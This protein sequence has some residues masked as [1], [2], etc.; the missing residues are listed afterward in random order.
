MPS[1]C[2]SGG[3]TWAPSGETIAVMQPPR[4][5]LR[6]FSSGEI[7]AICSSVSQPVALTTK[8]PL[9]KRVVADRHLDLLGENRSNHRAG[10]LGDV[11]FFVLRHQGVAGERIVVLP[12]GQRADAADGGIDNGEARAIAL[13]PDHPFMECRRDLAALER[14]PAVGVENKLRVVERTVIALVDAEHD[15]DVYGASP[16][17]ATASVTGPGTITAFS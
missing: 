1:P 9:S 2:V 12:A 13:P 17:A 10:K 7:F 15:H 16:T 4:S 11:D 8:Q 3:T 5:A 6:I 14:E